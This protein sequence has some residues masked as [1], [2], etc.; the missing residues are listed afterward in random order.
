[1]DLD[2]Q[3]TFRGLL[4]WKCAMGAFVL[5]LVWMALWPK[6]KAVERR[7]FRYL[8]LR[9]FHALTWL[10]LS[11]ASVLGMVRAPWAGVAARAVAF[12]ALGAYLVFMGCAL[13][14]SK[15]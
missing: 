5:G 15:P 3:Q 6:E 11:A 13:K 7:G 12:S 10:L 4:L 14:R 9:W 2:L 1:M 8:V